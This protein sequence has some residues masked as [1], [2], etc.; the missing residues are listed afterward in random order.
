M[1]FQS[2]AGR[3]GSGGDP[4][5]AVDRAHM[6]IDGHQADDEPLGDLRA[7][8]ALGEETQHVQLALRQ[9]IRDGNC[10]FRGRRGR[11]GYQL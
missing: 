3:G 7:G 8:Q 9:S 2:V 5:F 4:Q 10:F 1:M 6:R 11:R